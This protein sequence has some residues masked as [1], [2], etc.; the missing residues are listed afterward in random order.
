MSKTTK[1]KEKVI[2]YLLNMKREYTNNQLSID[3]SREI[4]FNS[5]IAS[6]G[7]EEFIKQL[8]ILETDGLINVKFHSGRR[9]LSYGISIALYSD[10]INYFD[11]KRKQ[12]KNTRDEWIK[13]WIPVSISIV[14][15]VIS[16][17]ALLLELKVIQP[18]QQSKPE[19]ETTDVSLPSRS[20]V[21]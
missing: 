5:C 1:I 7:E 21:Q 15:I 19:L 4:F 13:F 8:S 16:A 17:I 9:D 6:I 18:M 2:Q 12:A 20:S 3:I 11:N 10:I 14:A